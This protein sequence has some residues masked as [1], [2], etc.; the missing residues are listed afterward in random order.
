MYAMGFT[1]P[2]TEANDSVTITYDDSTLS[3]N[4][5]LSVSNLEVTSQL[6]MPDSATFSGLALSQTDYAPAFVTDSIITLSSVA[7]SIE[8]TPP[9]SMS[10]PGI[11]KI[12]MTGGGDGQ[13]LVITNRGAVTIVFQDTEADGNLYL[14]TDFSMAQWDS[15][16]LMYNSKISKWIEISRSDN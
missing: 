7:S 12:L 15:I 11:E 5:T 9:G 2:N 10:S 6:A 8:I 13:I 14:S 1:I 4:K 16:M 3:I